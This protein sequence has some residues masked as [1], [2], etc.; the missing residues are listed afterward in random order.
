MGAI[1]EVIHCATT[2]LTA[3]ENHIMTKGKVYGKAGSLGL[4]KVLIAAKLG[5]S[6]VTVAGESAPHDKFPLGV[7]PAYEGEKLL[8]GAESIAA[9]VAGVK[10]NAGFPELVQWLVWAER[11]L[12]PNVLGYVLPSISAAKVDDKTLNSYREELFAQLKQF[13]QLL[14]DRTYLVGERLSIADV[15]VAVDLIPA[16]QH[17]L[18]DNKRKEYQ[19]VTRWFRTIIAQK[20]VHQVVGDV[21]LAKE[22]AKFCKNKYDQLQSQHAAKPS[23]QQDKKKEDKP[24]KEQ[25]KKKEKDDDDDMGDEPVEKAPAKDPFADMPKANFNFD[26]FKKVYSN[27]DTATKALPYFW[28]HFDAA[29]MSIWK[30]TYKFPQDLT[31]SFMACNLISGMMQRLEKLNKNAFASMILF[32]TDNNLQIG[33]VWVFRG[34]Q[35]AFELSPD[36]Q[37]DYESYAWEKLDVSNDA[38][39]KLVNEYFLWEGDFEGKKFNQGKIFK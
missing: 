29:N 37:V 8:F 27:E 9:H 14:L 28:D 13:N 10:D 15:C 7:L 18:V 20:D 35:L 39:K 1:I 23:K 31:L 22:V 36:W 25:P 11:E 32:G 38:N 16:F 3:A 19:N 2:G 4:Q 5:G 12:L 24:A 17:V 33:G 34:H 21:Q 30:C 26:E 6:D